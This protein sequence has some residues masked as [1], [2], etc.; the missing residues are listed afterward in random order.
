MRYD[1]SKEFFKRARSKKASIDTS[2]KGRFSNKNNLMSSGYGGNRKGRRIK[3]AA[4]LGRHT[5]D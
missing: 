4:S 2:E 1:E 5:E 3:A